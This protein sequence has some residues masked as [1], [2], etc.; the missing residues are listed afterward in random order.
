MSTILPLAPAPAN[1]LSRSMGMK[2]FVVIL[3]AIGMSNLR[4][5]R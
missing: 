3:L 2:F 5:L 4:L 1:N